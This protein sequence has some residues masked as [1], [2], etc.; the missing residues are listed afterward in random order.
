MR[1]VQ[2][3]HGVGETKR[4][5]DGLL[6]D[7]EQKEIRLGPEMWMQPDCRVLDYGYFNLENIVY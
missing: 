6:D 2:Q 1:S 7:K 3:R 5:L 4:P